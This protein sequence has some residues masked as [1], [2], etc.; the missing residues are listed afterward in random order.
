MTSISSHEK[1]G[2]HIKEKLK[3]SIEDHRNW[4][5]FQGII[6]LLAGVLAIVLPVLSAIG[7]EII[8]GAVLFVSGVVQIIAAYRSQMHWWVWLSGGLSIVVSGLML[9]YPIAGTIALA[10]L[11]AAFLLLEGIFEILLSLEI[12]P[13][14][15]WGWIL[16]SGIVSLLLAILLFLNW[17]GTTVWFLGVVVGI[18][19]L[20]Y[21]FSILSLTL[22]TRNIQNTSGSPG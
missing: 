6:F 1:S 8:A 19:L 20:L 3:T 18:N 2:S 4:Y 15:N 21:G 17:P 14:K 11:L 7:F 10:S 5:I 13:L 12:R 22:T 9:L 16:F